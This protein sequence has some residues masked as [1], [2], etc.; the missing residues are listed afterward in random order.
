MEH[1]LFKIKRGETDEGKTI[2]KWWPPSAAFLDDFKEWIA[3]Q[4]RNWNPDEGVWELEDAALPRLD[5]L[6][7]HYGARV[8]EM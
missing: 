8:V 6:I 4:H 3:P 1:P 2:L 7:R 5:D